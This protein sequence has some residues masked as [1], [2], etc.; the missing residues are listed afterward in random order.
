MKHPLP[1][2]LVYTRQSPT[3][4]KVREGYWVYATSVVGDPQPICYVV[5]DGRNHWVA[6]EGPGRRYRTWSR[7]GAVSAFLRGEGLIADS[8][9][10]G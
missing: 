7:L 9:F 5:R 10:P 8:T 6:F 4:F 3:G 2:R 1:I